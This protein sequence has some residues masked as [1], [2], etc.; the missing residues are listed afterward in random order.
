MENLTVL[1]HTE[2]DPRMIERHISYANS[3]GHRLDIPEFDQ[4]KKE[5]VAIVAGGPS[6]SDHVDEIKRL[7]SRIIACNGAY[8]FLLEKGIKPWAVLCMDPNDEN[9]QF[10]FS[11]RQRSD[12]PY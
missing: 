7:N 3:L 10:L 1:D 11:S 6:L 5:S 2:H 4:A 8:K 9:A 12:A